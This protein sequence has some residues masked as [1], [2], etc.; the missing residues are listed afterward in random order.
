MKIFL[1]VV[2]LMLYSLTGLAKQT[3]LISSAKTKSAIIS[4]ILA[5][6]SLSFNGQEIE[7]SAESYQALLLN[8]AEVRIT[9]VGG[10]KTFYVTADKRSIDLKWKKANAETKVILKVEYPTITEMK[11][12]RNNIFFK[13][14]TVTNEAR[15]DTQNIKCKLLQTLKAGR[16]PGLFYFLKSIGQTQITRS[17]VVI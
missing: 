11:L 6:A 16:N 2:S 3:D 8:D 5:P 10:L 12:I 1:V 17:A 15:L 14:N 13:F 4:G 9:E 7:Q